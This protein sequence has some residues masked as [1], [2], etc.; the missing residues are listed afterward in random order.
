MTVPRW[1]EDRAA[2]ARVVTDLLAAEFARLRPGG[3]APP[4]PRPWPDGL[5]IDGADVG[6]PGDGGLGADSLDRLTLAGALNEALHLHRS[7]IEDYLLVRRRFGEW[8]EVAAAALARFDGQL[9]FRT[10]GSTGSAKSCT[11]PLS[12]LEEEADALAAIFAGRRRVVALVPAHHIYGFLFTVL[13]PARLA[14]PV[15]DGRDRSPAGVAA[16]LRHGDL[17]VAHP[18]W[19]GALLRSGAALPEDVVGSSSTAPCPPATALA[20]RERGLARLVEVFGSSETAGLGWR[21][22]PDAAFQPFPWWGFGA[23]GVVSRTLPDATVLTA[24]LQDRLAFDDDGRFRPVG[25][26]DTVVQVGGV[27]VAL[28]AVRAHLLTHPAVSDCAV[29]LMRPAEGTRLKA[30]IVP[31]KDAPPEAELRRTLEEWID[32]TLPT[33]ERPRALAFGDRLPVNAIG[34]AADWPIGV[35]GS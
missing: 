33:A 9:T 30:F 24:T 8:L 7:G 17:V 11:H 27:N 22:N 19:W 6:G 1:W 10:S 28:G 13:V 14:A 2:L 34:K 25:R 3:S 12:A 20:L 21:D 31:T 32:Q 5:S 4:L 16:G 23:D 18:D 29:R 35:T 26:V 15:T